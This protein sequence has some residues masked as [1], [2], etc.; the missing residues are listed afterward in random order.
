MNRRSFLQNAGLAG[1][2]L[3]VAGATGQELFA[4][5][6]T[7]TV[8]D[9]PYNLRFRHV[10]LDFH[11]SELIDDVA[12]NFDPEQFAQTLKKAHVN[13][14]NVFARCHHGMLYYDSKKFP[15]RIH[16][17]LKRNLLKEQI[18]ACHK[19]DIRTP[20]Y[21][22]VGW[23]HFSAE[24]HPEWLLIDETGKVIGTEPQKPGFYRELDLSN[25]QYVQ[26]LKDHISELFETMPVDGL[27][28]DI[29]RPIYGYNRKH[30]DA[31][32][33][34][35]LDINN[36]LHRHK[37]YT[38][39]IDNFKHDMSAHI[40]K[41]DK[42]ANIFYNGGHIGPDI[43]NTIA[44]N[45]HLELESLPSGGWGYMHFPLTGRYARTQGY[46]LLG[47]TGKFHASWGDFHSLKNQ[48]AM[49]YEIFTMLALTAKCSIG[50]QLHPR[51]VLD[52]ATYDLI[53]KVY[54]SVEQKEPWCEGAKAVV[55]IGVLSPEAFNPPHPKPG[56]GR[57]PEPAQ[58]VVR[59][60]QEG[61]HMF[62]VIDPQADLNNYKLIIMPD[63]ISIDDTMAKKLEAYVAKGGAV[64]ASFESGLKK[65]K[66]AFASNIFGVELVGNA[67]YSPD[68]IVTNGAIAKGLPDSELAMYFRGKEVKNIGGEVLADVNVPYFNRSYEHFS[69]HNHTP[70]AE[71]KGYPGIVQKGK[72][73]YFAHPIFEQY[74]N[75]APAWCKKLVLN[76][77]DRLLPVKVLAHDGP[78]TVLSAINDQAKQSRLVT[79]AL[80]YIAE[81][82]GAAFDV[83][84]DVIP[85][86]NLGFTVNTDKKIKSAKLVP[87]NTVIK[88]KQTGSA[89]SFTIPKLTGHQ[90]VEL[91]YK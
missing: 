21:S 84:E 74:S 90:M 79:H 55:D 69:S 15:E 59:M 46:D 4:N 25:P 77:I 85:L 30:I 70:S 5:P 65:D 71:K 6:I 14:V 72:V 40:R 89:V 29:I 51:G 26:F 24:Q 78:S 39:V 86:H 62:D 16:P 27:W 35:G 23:D 58:G 54:S 41:M 1:A 2:G 17:S 88:F 66:K 12:K 73:I 68:F 61:N 56:W 45:T 18:E 53:G 20:I 19:L 60:L 75:N 36:H 34:K 76:A 28:L 11:T 63:S 67:P 83:I 13:S 82:R 32:R 80:H 47:M 7:G 64:L 31:M 38:E 49:E 44:D 87:S 42:N 9:A 91:S 50:D 52:R 3:M 43:Q 22:T 37:Y 33:K 10:H 57:V 48:A 81:R 8:A